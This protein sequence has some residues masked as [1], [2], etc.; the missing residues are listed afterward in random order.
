MHKQQDRV[1]VVSCASLWQ[2]SPG[3]GDGD[4]CGAERMASIVLTETQPE[5]TC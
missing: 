5:V 2:S 4:I 3:H 1:F